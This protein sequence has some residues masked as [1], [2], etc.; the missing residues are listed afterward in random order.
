MPKITRYLL[1]A[2]FALTPLALLIPQAHAQTVPAAFQTFERGYMIWLSDTDDIWVLYDNGTVNLFPFATYDPLPDNPVADDVPEGRVKPVR[3]FGRVWG[4]YSFVRNQLGW[5]VQDEFYYEPVRDLTDTDLFVTFPDGRTA[6]ING[7]NTTW[8]FISVLAPQPTVTPVAA[9]ATVEPQHTTR[10]LE[11]ITYQPFEGGFMLY[12]EETGAIWVLTNGG[13]AT[14]FTT[15][16]YGDLAP[17]SQIRAPQ[18]QFVPE[19]GMGKVWANFPVVRQALGFATDIERGYLGDFETIRA[20]RYF[21]LFRIDL[22][23]ERRVVIS[24]STWYYG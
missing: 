21:T 2:V 1:L 9:P 14:L 20:G 15:N 5:G 6:F 10:G 12:R 7:A 16:A 4:N 18:G 8:E 22:P 23:D 13:Q 24:G 3:G 19:F 17:T 11:Y